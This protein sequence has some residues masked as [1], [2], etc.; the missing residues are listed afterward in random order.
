[1][2]ASADR[3]DLVPRLAAIVDELELVAADKADVARVLA[4]SLFEDAE[5]DSATPRSARQFG[6]RLT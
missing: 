2:Q 6:P 1:M 4:E 3:L 5:R